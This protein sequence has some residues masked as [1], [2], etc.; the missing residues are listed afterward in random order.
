M[1]SI[2][3]PGKSPETLE[4]EPGDYR[5]H[6]GGTTDSLEKVGS[7]A[8]EGTEIEWKY[9]TAPSDLAMDSWGRDSQPSG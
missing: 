1:I 7:T 6:E 8:Y 4:A 2:R 9:L 3:Q 5:W